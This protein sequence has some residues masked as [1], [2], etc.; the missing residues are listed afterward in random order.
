MMKKT[1]NDV[2][3]LCFCM[4]DMLGEVKNSITDEMVRVKADTK[5]STYIHILEY[6]MDEG[7][8]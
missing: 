3:N 8:E 5:I 4:I 1:M 2:V 6:I 7:D